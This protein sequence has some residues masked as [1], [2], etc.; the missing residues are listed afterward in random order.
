[1]SLMSTKRA[2][3]VALALALL[4]AGLAYLLWPGRPAAPPIVAEAPQAV[5]PAPAPAS[6]QPPA[7][8]AS[9]VRHPIEPAPDG[10]PLPPVAEAGRAVADALETLL[11][12]GDLLR[13]L[14]PEGF[15]RHAVA[16][17]D[18]LG[19]EHAAPRLWPVVP[20]PGRFSTAAQ[21]GTVRI[22]TA[23]AARYEPFVRFAVAIDPARAAA[24]Y[25]RFHPWFQQAYE[26]LGYPG[27]PFN[28]R[29]VEVIDLLL[30]TPEPAD[31]PAVTLTEVKGPIEPR[32]PWLHQRFADPA[33][34]AR[35]AGQ[36]ILLRMGAEHTRALKAQLAAFRAEIATP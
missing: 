29:L 36:K 30:Q 21:D 18:A 32:Q 28:D 16:S 11:G 9:A 8:A 13:F 23:N 5:T 33:L 20:T 26:D 35:P 24:F 4:A 19:R 14:R 31:A 12:R 3:L 1:M 6:A 7:A 10:E 34:E 27:R 22:A 25:R 17:V 15:V 2:A